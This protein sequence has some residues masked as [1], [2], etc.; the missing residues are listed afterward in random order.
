MAPDPHHTCTDD[1]CRRV[2]QVLVGDTEQ[3][4]RTTPINGFRSAI[5]ASALATGQD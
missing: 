4:R 2:P 1:W 3:Q 5:G